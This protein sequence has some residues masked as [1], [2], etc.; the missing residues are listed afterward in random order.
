MSGFSYLVNLYVPASTAV[1]VPHKQRRCPNTLD[2]DPDLID[3]LCKAELF[4]YT[5]TMITLSH[6]LLPPKWIEK[7]V[8]SWP[9]KKKILDCILRDF[10]AKQIWPF[11]LGLDG[12]AA[13]EP[14]TVAGGADW[15]CQEASSPSQSQDS[16]RPG[17]ETSPLN[18]T[19]NFFFPFL[20][21]C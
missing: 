21:F 5:L 6:E 17:K 9:Q 19:L 12:G 8:K 15:K 7:Q 3:K 2:S 18:Y 13:E 16:T 11:F 20:F 10:A 14:F 4:D 1:M